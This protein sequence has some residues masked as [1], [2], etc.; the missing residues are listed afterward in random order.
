MTLSFLINGNFFN[1]TLIG[2][3]F[4]NGMKNG[5]IYA[6]M[7][8]T[9][10][11]IYKTTGHLNFAQGEMG[12][13]GAFDRFRV[14]ARARLVVLAGHPDRA[15]VLLSARRGDRAHA[16]QAH[17]AAQRARGRH[18]HARDLPR[19]QRAERGDLGDAAAHAAHTLPQPARRPARHRR[20][21]AAVRGRDTE[22]SARGSPSPSSSRS[23]GSSSRRR[24]SASVTALSPRTGSRAS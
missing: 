2:Q 15:R 19:H 4:V 7:A 1:W 10:V 21:P 13:M 9:V 22:R 16:D 6:L 14:G 17:R 23:S 24:S 12:T 18:R 20:G 5:A 8:L 11:I 3:L